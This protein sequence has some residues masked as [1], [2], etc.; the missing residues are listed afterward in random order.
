MKLHQFKPIS[1]EAVD[2]IYEVALVEDMIDR[3]ISDSKIIAANKTGVDTVNCRFNVVRNIKTGTKA[4]S[5]TYWISTNK[6]L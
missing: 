1:F 6:H 2:T 3:A 5:N 4:T